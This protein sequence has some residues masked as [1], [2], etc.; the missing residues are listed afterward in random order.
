M[1]EIFIQIN[2]PRPP[3]HEVAVHLWG[4]EADYDSDGNSETPDSQS[5]TELTIEK[6]PQEGLR[7]D[8]DPIS[9]NPLVLKVISEHEELAESVAQFLA[10]QCPGKIIQKP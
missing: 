5:W 1:K 9:L 10:V 6:R 7:V 2:G 4:E 8:V 3:C